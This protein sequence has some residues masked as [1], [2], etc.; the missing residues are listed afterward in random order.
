MF[1]SE[2]ARLLFERYALGK[3]L[4]LLDPVDL[5][6]YSQQTI[7][8]GTPNPLHVMLGREGYLARI[9]AVQLDRALV[10]IQ[11]AALTRLKLHPISIP[12]LQLSRNQTVEE[13]SLWGNHSMSQYFSFDIPHLEF[14]R[15]PEHCA[16]LITGFVRIVLEKS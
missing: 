9:D 7:W 11:L 3:G 16:P 10:G 14:V 2:V 4:I 6:V 15:I 8:R 13:K 1:A 12:T 5:Q